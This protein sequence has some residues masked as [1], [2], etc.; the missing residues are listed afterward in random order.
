MT[1]VTYTDGAGFV[2]EVVDPFVALV[3]EDRR[4]R[5]REAKRL[6]DRAWAAMALGPSI[7]IAQ[8]LYRGRRVPREVLEARFR[9]QLVCWDGVLTDDLV[10][11]VL[12]LVEAYR[13][14][15]DLEEPSRPAW[16]RR[17]A[18]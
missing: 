3:I 2:H 11:D 7:V 16:E 4:Q 1:G 15:G 9:D 17:R 13:L 6:A 14:A 12:V 8:A 18:A 5:E 10:L